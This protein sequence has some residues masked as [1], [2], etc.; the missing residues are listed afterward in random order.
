MIV[1]IRLE[2]QIAIWMAYAYL[3]LPFLLVR[4]FWYLMT[5]FIRWKDG[6]TVVEL[7]RAAKPG[8][9]LFLGS[10]DPKIAYFPV[11]HTY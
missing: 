10:L 8:H 11:S 2:M 6:K 7:S 1:M 4:G 3:L 5:R 9:E